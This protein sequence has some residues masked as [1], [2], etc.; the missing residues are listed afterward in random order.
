MNREI[1]NPSPLH[2]IATGN[3]QMPEGSASLTLRQRLKLW[4]NAQVSNPSFRRWATRFWLTKSFAKRQANELFKITGGF[5]YSQILF[6]CVELDLFRLLQATPKTTIEILHSLNAAKPD[7]THLAEPALENLLQAAENLKLICSHKGFDPFKKY[8][9]LDDFGAVIAADEGI[10][11]MVRHHAML[12]RDLADPV[13]LM[14]GNI[15]HTETA[16]FWAYANCEKPDALESE[17]VSAYSEL[18]RHSQAMI[19]EVVLDAYPFDNIRSVL[20]IGGGNG[21]FLG[22]LHHKHPHIELGLF[23][24]P[25]VAEEAMVHFRQYNPTAVLSAKGGNFFEDVIDNDADLL[26][27]VRI[28]CDHNDQAVLRLLK[29]LHSSMKPHA[30]L[31]IAEAMNGKSDGQRLASA[32]FKLY[33]TAMRSGQCRTP[34]RIRELL[35]EAGFSTTRVMKTTN[36][37]LATLIHAQT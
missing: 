20:D 28:L 13:A 17:K 25:S 37:L 7:S 1:G 5:V 4:R 3:R 6:A 19:A 16:W 31:L 29:N 33:F 9:M 8:W 21:A 22:H 12:Y 36:P 18:M 34:S 26:T 30:S 14:S 32:Y 11:A 15:P 35:A 27:L 24:L 2:G 10:S 23:D